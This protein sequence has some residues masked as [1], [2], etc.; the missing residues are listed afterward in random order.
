MDNSN[1]IIPPHLNAEVYRTDTTGTSTQAN[2]DYL[3]I[4]SDGSFL[5]GCSEL[6]GRYWDGSV[7]IYTPNVNK[8][9]NIPTKKDI[10]L[11]SG[12]SDGCF[13]ESSR[14]VFL[15]E[16]SGAVSIWSSSAENDAWKIW[17][18]EL[19]VAEH[20][21]AALVVESL[22]PSSEYVTGGA[23]GNIK[24]WDITDLLC[25]KHYG[26]A[27]SKAIY[28]IAVRPTSNSTF[29]TGSLDYYI[30]LWNDNTN[31]SALD[32]L[33]NDCG[34]R[35]VKWIN[36]NQLIYGDE[37]GVVGVVD[38]R[39]PNKS[40]KLAQ[41]PAAVHKLTLQS[42][43]NRV[44]VCCDNK[45]VSVFSISEGPKLSSVYENRTLHTKFVRDAA[46]DVSERNLLYTLGWDG[47]IKTHLVTNA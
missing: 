1:K 6:T 9:C 42:E 11:T 32:I 25:V 21:D 28:S 45:I 38:V 29:A 27:H 2:L 47:E 5:V 15:C 20:D 35:C 31:N 13:I 37:A 4:H 44:A 43:L 30:S 34:V 8:K 17:T 24:V 33:K 14:K 7:K 40:E 46:W 23:D 16:D 3:R 22:H 36:E 41:L 18:E 26:D 12:T 10:C 39:N 19:S